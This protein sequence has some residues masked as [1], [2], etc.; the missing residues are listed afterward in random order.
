MTEVF[1]KRSGMSARLAERVCRRNDMAWKEIY[2]SVERRFM[3]V[4]RLW[5]LRFAVAF[6]LGAAAAYA[7]DLPLQPTA[8]MLLALIMALVVLAIKKVG[9]LL[10]VAFFLF[11]AVVGVYVMSCA[12]DEAAMAPCQDYMR[13]DAVVMSQPQHKGKTLR[14]D[15]LILNVKG[16]DAE[17][18]MVKMSMA[19][20]RLDVKPGDAFDC[21]SVFVRPRYVSGNFDY[22]RYLATQG[23]RATT[24]VYAK[25]M[26]PKKISTAGLPCYYRLRLS[27]LG[28]RH[29]M[30]SM[31]LANGMSGD[32]LAVIQALTLGDKSALTS[33]MRTLYSVAGASHV[34]ALSGMHLSVIFTL[35]ML[36][37]ARVRLT[38]WRLLST[39]FVV[40]L[41]W[42]YVMLVGMP[43]SAVRS[44]VMLSVLS[45]S[46]AAHRGRITWAS[47]SAAAVVVVVTSPLSLLDV[48]FQM[49]FIAVAAILLFVPA[50]N[51]V[52]FRG[53]LWQCGGWRWVS[54]M[55]SVSIA[56]QM[57]VAPL[58]AYYFGRFSCYFLLTNF[59]AV[60][61]AAFLLYGG[62]AMLLL[63]GFPLLQRLA[64]FALD[65]ALTLLGDALG[66]IAS[67]PMAS[68]EGIRLSGIGVFLLYA[69]LLSV[70]LLLRRF[71]NYHKFILLPW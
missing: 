33:D 58:T 7:V 32:N 50:I 36:P 29:K 1:F 66:F 44:A 8:W 37:L 27:M 22:A 63:Q 68:V 2:R 35:L 46:V 61:L 4:C 55:S 41:V 30:L 5:I 59:I 19:A 6:L 64:G 39:A 9:R 54:A 3:P 48:G 16:C 57:G 42:L 28:L 15:A 24:F 70:Y 23:Y 56:A 71:M 10:S 25:D 26:M 40:A 14:F 52:L 62:V 47:L 65:S 34:L 20:H 67:L 12:K 51:G 69:L 21:I 13:Y 38:R 18:F 31:Y 17:P 43:L 49:S 60:P 45:L 53:A 11:S